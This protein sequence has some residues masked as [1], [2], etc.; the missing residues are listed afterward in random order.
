MIEIESKS[1][2]EFLQNLSLLNKRFTD[3]WGGEYVFRGQGDARWKL[4]PKAFRAGTKTPIADELATGTMATYRDQRNLE[5]QMLRYFVLEINRNG[6]RLPDDKLFYKLVD[7]LEASDEETKIGRFEE[8]WPSHEYYSLLSLAQHYGLPTRLMDWSRSSLVSAF[9]AA[10]D[11]ASMKTHGAKVGKLAVYA[12]N[13]NSM[14]LESPS[15]VSRTS[16]F[17]PLFKRNSRTTYHVLEVP[18]SHNPNLLAQKGL[19]ICCSEYGQIKNHQFT[20][21]SLDD[22][23]AQRLV[24][25]HKQSVDPKDPGPAKLEKIDQAFY[26][27]TLP[28]KLAPTLF[29]ALDKLHVNPSTIYPGIEGCVKTLFARCA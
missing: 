9:F 25:L 18:T 17:D 5:W 4:F 26:K 27:F 24:Y 12:L 2:E 1:V 15:W 21:I 16:L 8:P 20:P 23:L 28:S 3:V 11:C 6:H 10:S 19:F 13:I 7:V 22:Y 14:L 29:A